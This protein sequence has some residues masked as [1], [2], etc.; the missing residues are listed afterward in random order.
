[1]EEKKEAVEQVLP[2]V[3]VKINEDK[4]CKDFTFIIPDNCQYSVAKLGIVSLF[5]YIVR[6]EYDAIKAQ[7]AKEQEEKEAPAQE[8]KAEIL[9]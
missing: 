3:S 5:E 2:K 6:L 8:V 7:A 4:E 9:G 1:M